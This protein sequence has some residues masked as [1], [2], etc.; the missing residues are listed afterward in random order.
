MSTYTVQLKSEDACDYLLTEAGEYI[1]TEDGKLIW[2]D[3]CLPQP[4]NYIS[5]QLMPVE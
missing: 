4:K 1:L 5:L 3:D 2:I